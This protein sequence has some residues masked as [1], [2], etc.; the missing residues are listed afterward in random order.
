MLDEIFKI[1]GIDLVVRNFLIEYH[2]KDMQS[3]HKAI[4]TISF[5]AYSD[6]MTINGIYD[7]LQKQEFDLYYIGEVGGTH[8][9]K[10]LETI[11]ENPFLCAKYGV[12]TLYLDS[13]MAQI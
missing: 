7:D 13:V 9:L 6:E 8:T 1:L 4:Q 11:I 2:D 10:E 5:K 12:R 3:Y